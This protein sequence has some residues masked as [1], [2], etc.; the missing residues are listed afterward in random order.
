[1]FV[2]HNVG[3]I[4]FFGRFTRRIRDTLLRS[5]PDV[6]ALSNCFSGGRRS[7]HHSAYGDC[8]SHNRRLMQQCL[9]CLWGHHCS[10]DLC[11]SC[12]WG[13]RCMPGKRVI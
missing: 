13:Q 8:T 3:Y 9:C 2:K 10:H 11:C 12:W 7:Q 6:T 4:H 1:M 5:L